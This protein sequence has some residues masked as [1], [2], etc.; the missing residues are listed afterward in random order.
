MPNVRNADVDYDSTCEW[1]TFPERLED[2]GVSWKIYQNE[3]SLD[4]GFTRE[5]DAWLANFTDNP[6]EWFE[7]YN[8]WILGDLPPPLDHRAATLP[9][10]IEQ[11][12]KSPRAGRCGGGR[13]A[14][15]GPRCDARRELRKVIS[16]RAQMDCGG[17]ARNCRRASAACTTGPSRRTPPTLHTANF[18]HCATATAAQSREM[19]IPKGDVLHQFREGCAR[20][21]SFPRSPGWSRPRS[22]PIIRHRPGTARGTLPKRSN[23]LTQQSGGLEE[24]HLHPDLRRERRLLRSRAA[25][26][27]A[28]SGQP[29]NRQ[30]LSEASTPQLE[31]LHLGAGPQATPRAGCAR[32]T[33]RASAF[34]C[35]W[36][37][38]RH[39]AAAASSARRSSTTPPCCNFW[40]RC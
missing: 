7:Q 25:V 4:T 26:R 35:R 24:D 14:H 17:A 19:A 28:G 6:I 16:E 38:R 29:G 13:K 15:Q 12:R 37:L 3:L 31:Y 33:G 40:R 23:I 22:F 9:A 39:G 30:D 8:V 20:P 5:E 27:R 18:R 11:L 32:R 10:E 34:G 2:A 36:W 1:K 21:G